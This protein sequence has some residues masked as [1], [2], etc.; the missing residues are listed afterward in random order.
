MNEISGRYIELPDEAYI[1]VSLRKQSDNN[2]QASVESVWVEEDYAEVMKIYEESYKKS[3]EAYKK[4]LEKGVAREQARALIPFGFFTKF[5]TS[6]N[7]R[8]LIHWY[9]L[10]IDIHAQWEHQQFA[11]AA[12]ELLKDTDIKYSIEALIKNK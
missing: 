8:N 12:I 1:P 11:T 7:L 4:V 3:Y 2:K 6:I 9:N 5:V 10:R